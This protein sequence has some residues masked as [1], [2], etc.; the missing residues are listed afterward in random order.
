MLSAS[1]LAFTATTTFW[2][3]LIFLFIAGAALVITGIAAQ[4]LVQSAVDRSMRGRVMGLYGMIFRGGPALNA[5]LIGLF[6]A[7]YGLRWPLAVG[8]GICVLLGFWAR[9]RQR[10]LEHALEFAPQ[11]AAAD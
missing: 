8:A 10:T 4:T 9:W 11:P 7:G 6:S 1:L 2:L 3:A 5:L